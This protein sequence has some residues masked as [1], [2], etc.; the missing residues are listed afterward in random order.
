MRYL[1]MYLIIIALSC[2]TNTTPSIEDLTK[3]YMKDSVVPYFH[4]PN[5]YEFVSIEKPDSITNHYVA[6]SEKQ[7][8]LEELQKVTDKQHDNSIV[9]IADKTASTGTTLDNEIIQQ[10]KH[11]DSLYKEHIALLNAQIERCDK[12]LLKPDSLNHLLIK[13]NYRGKN[14]MGALILDKKNLKYFPIKN[15]IIADE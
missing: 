3:S 14:K 4:D 1:S 12:R 5:S 10:G 9:L 15:K 11:I 6:L 2:K 7:K 8:Y 13:V